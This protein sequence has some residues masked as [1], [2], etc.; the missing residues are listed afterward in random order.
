MKIKVSELLDCVDSLSSIVDGEARVADS[1]EIERTFR[2]IHDYLHEL[3]EKGG[4][5]WA[6]PE[7]QKGMQS[8]MVLAAEAA[9]MLDKQGSLGFSVAEMEAYQKLQNFYV[10]GLAH[11]LKEEIFVEEVESFSDEVGKQPIEKI[12]D[13]RADKNYELF[14]ITRED[15]SPYFRKDLIKH[16]RLLGDFE[17]IILAMG[18]DDP[19]SR[20]KMLRDRD[21][22][23]SAQEILR[24][25]RPHIDAFYKVAMHHKDSRP[26]VASLNKA[27][28]AL[29]LSGNPINLVQN[30]SGKNCIDYYA[31]FHAYLRAALVSDE[32]KQALLAPSKQMDSFSH[33]LLGLSHSLACFFFTRVSTS[34]EAIGW[35]HRMLYREGGQTILVSTS[36][37]V[38]DQIEQQDAHMRKLFQHHP[39]GPLLRAAHMI[40]KQEELT[41]FD[42]LKQGAFPHQLFDFTYNGREMTCMRLPCPT[43]QMSIE[44]GH[45]VEEF[46]GL[47]HYFQGQITPQKHLC[48][49][50]EDRTSWREHT[51]SVL[52]E[53]LSSTHEEI[54]YVITL[55]RSTTFYLQEGVYA[56][57]H[58]AK[59]FMKQMEEQVRSEEACGFYF[60]KNIDKKTLFSYAQ[61]VIGSIFQSVFGGKN[62]LTKQNRSD[63][64][65]IFYQLLTFKLLDMIKPDVVS[66]TCKDAIDTGSVAAAGFYAMLKIMRDREAVT[67]SQ[68]ERDM[69]LW[70]LQTPALLERGRT[71]E[72]ETLHRQLHA[73]G[74]FEAE[75]LAGRERFFEEMF[76]RSG[77]A[78]SSKKRKRA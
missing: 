40:K 16:V 61:A 24:L 73:L 48:I 78:S 76:P 5:A 44:E 11:R 12:S 13:V 55:P 75:M 15:G 47:L 38:W 51:R 18:A 33:I 65:E 67:W 4:G 64:I 31:D 52:I 53:T 3:H 35:I 30:T 36:H 21:I 62:V 46:E 34:Q 72:K 69:M 43:R 8:I 23:Q 77:E 25:A 50:L 45:V 26:F 63:F 14:Y 28:M 29:M 58:D 2:V 74:T 32:Y 19:F 1:R 20:L 39:N 37:S 9:Y 6:D 54:F 10:T 57:V 17:E 7:V 49:H 71:V 59:I 42:P 27:L 70:I 41:G 60:S 66:F 56:D 68:E 22:H